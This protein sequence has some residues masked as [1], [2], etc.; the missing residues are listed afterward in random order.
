MGR[1]IFEKPTDP[2]FVE[3]SPHFMKHEVSSHI[4][5]SPLPVPVLGQSNPVPTFP[6][7]L[8]KIHSNI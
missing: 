5:K 7:H 8:T 2:Q 4:Q 1:V 3:N 6:P